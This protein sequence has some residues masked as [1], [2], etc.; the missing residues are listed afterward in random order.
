M[1]EQ[2]QDPNSYQE[3]FDIPSTGSSIPETAPVEDSIQEL[4]DNPVLT[5]EVKELT[6]FRRSSEYAHNV[7][8]TRPMT[9]DKETPADLTI[10]LPSAAVHRSQELI[11]RFPNLSGLTYGPDINW[12]QRYMG[13][14]FMATYGHGLDASLSRK[15]SEWGQGAE[16]NGETIK[17]FIPVTKRTPGQTL[18][19]DQTI[20]MAM[21]HL[22]LGDYFMTALWES[23]FWVMFR[24]VPD[25]V[26]IEINRLLGI[27]DIRLS[28]AT[29][30][31]IHSGM[32]SLTVETIINAIL[33]YVHRTSVNQAQLPLTDIP[34]YMSTTDK[35]NFI[36]GFIVSNYP[37]GFTSERSCFA[38][39]TKCRHVV[40][41]TLEIADMQLVDYKGL[42]E[43]AI[44][45]MR[46][47]APGSMSLESVLEYQKKIRA[48]TDKI[49]ELKTGS[50]KTI[51]MK[52]SIP[53]LLKEFIA[54]TEH[55]E[56]IR[57]AVLKT[58]TSDTPVRERDRLMEEYMVS[59][60]LA[61]YRHWVNQI[62]VTEAFPIDDEKAI[63]DTLEVLTKD[64]VLRADF[65]AKMTEF[66]NNT[67][68]S[69]IAIETL[70]C[71]NCGATH[72][73]ENALNPEF[74]DCVP[75]DL[76][77]LFSVIAEHKTRVVRARAS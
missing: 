28:R 14:L 21:S 65:F 29:Y 62:V 45:H 46:S 3:E 37:H 66:I 18:T 51:K 30:G 19:T 6:D 59:A 32:T 71:P 33:P 36:W 26:W 57:D 16:Y 41:D 42:G 27:H 39:I 54:M 35:Y 40:T 63:A 75:V 9:S 12:S 49:V 58:V 8:I 34:K 31:L 1:T 69:L 43:D 4:P 61:M 15:G 5:K 17:S 48:R 20:Q 10:D 13:G 70:K 76:I 67:S 24:P 38:D 53:S 64:H 52:L 22:G 60:E 44:L 47:K 25:Y 73:N 55:V 2:N 50:Q 74:R 72:S 77:Q 7:K 23:G 68:F 56:K 11:E